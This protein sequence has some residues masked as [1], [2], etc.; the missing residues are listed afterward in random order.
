[1]QQILMLEMLKAEREGEGIC[2]LK[3]AEMTGET[4]TGTHRKQLTL[5]LMNPNH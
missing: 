2:A 1:M 3:E 5:F 4:V